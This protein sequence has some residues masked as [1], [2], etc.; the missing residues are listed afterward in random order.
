MK[1]GDLLAKMRTTSWRF[2]SWIQRKALATWFTCSTNFTQYAF[3]A[4]LLH[5]RLRKEENKR[6]R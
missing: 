1:G 5:E 2:S 6:P 4:S 3:S